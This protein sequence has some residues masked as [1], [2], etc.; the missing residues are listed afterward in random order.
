MPRQWHYLYWRYHTKSNEELAVNRLY[1]TEDFIMKIKFYSFLLLNLA[2]YSSKR[3][4]ISSSAVY[5]SVLAQ[6]NL[7]R[8]LI[9]IFRIITFK[10][11][12]PARFCLW[13]LQND[14]IWFS[15][16]TFLTR[17]S[18]YPSAYTFQ[19]WWCFGIQYPIST[20]I[21]CFTV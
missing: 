1:I 13:N 12:S 15:F 14:F 20:S 3:I 4:W 19:Q 9:S 16:W 11:S 5:F 7:N 2:R 8:F 17:P 18:I 6:R 21:I 10:I